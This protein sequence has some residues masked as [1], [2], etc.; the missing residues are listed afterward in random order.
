MA[1]ALGVAFF[2]SCIGMQLNERLFPGLH[3]NRPQGLGRS[4]PEELCLAAYHISG[5]TVDVFLPQLL[6]TG[7]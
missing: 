1:T 4:S 5:M 3:T 6:D 2:S 7:R